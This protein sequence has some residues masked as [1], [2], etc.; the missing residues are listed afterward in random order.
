MNSD[1]FASQLRMLW[2][3]RERNY[4][5]NP[6]HIL[7]SDIFGIP[8]QMHGLRLCEYLLKFIF[9]NN[10]NERLLTFNPSC[11]DEGTVFLIAHDTIIQMIQ[12]IT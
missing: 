9:R 11:F 5:T 10:A 3:L 7:L 8:N 12:Y 6:T 2:Y 1:L 4:L